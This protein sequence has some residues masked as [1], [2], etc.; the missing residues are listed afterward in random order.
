MML[1]MVAIFTW[2]SYQRVPAWT[3]GDQLNFEGIKVSKNSARL[4]MYVGVTYFNF[5]KAEQN[6]DKNIII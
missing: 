3:N 4:N 1:V 5:Y 6:Q 2:I